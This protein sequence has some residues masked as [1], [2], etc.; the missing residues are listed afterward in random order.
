MAVLS[1]IIIIHGCIE[2][3]RRRT[4][5]KKAAKAGSDSVEQ[6]ERRPNNSPSV[7]ATAWSMC[8]AALLVYVFVLVAVALLIVLF[9]PTRF[10]R[11]D[12]PKREWKSGDKLPEA[13]SSEGDETERGWKHSC[14]ELM[15]FAKDIL[16]NRPKTEWDGALDY[17]GMCVLQE[18][19]NPAPRWNIAVALIEMGRDDEAL[20]FVLRALSLEPTNTDFL[21]TGGAFLSKRGYHKEAVECVERYLTLSLRVPSWEHLLASLSVQRE[22]EYVFL[23]ELGEDVTLT[24]ELLLSLYIQTQSLIKSGYLYKVLIGL[25]GPENDAELIKAYAFFSFG[26]GD[27]ATGTK[28]LRMVS[29]QLYI[30]QGYGDVDE[31][32]NILTAHCLRMLTASFDSHIVG[33]ARNLLMS[34]DVVMEELSYHCSLDD[35]RRN[36]VQTSRQT[37][38]QK[39]LR[40]ILALC[41]RSQSVVK[42]LLDEGAVVY[43]ENIF[44]WNPLLHA[45]ALGSPELVQELLGRGADP[46]SRTALAHTSLHVAAIRGGYDVVPPLV[47]AGLNASDVDYFGRTALQVACLQRWTAEGTAAAL[48]VRLL[49]REC[50]APLLY[51]PPLKRGLH[52][53]W[54]GSGVQLPPELTGEECGFDV[55]VSPDVHAFLFNY[56]ALQRPVLIRNATNSHEMKALFHLWQRN[57]LEQEFGS[58]EFHVV[59]VPYVKA[60]AYQDSNVTTLKAFLATMREIYQEHKN[61]AKVED[62]PGPQHVFEPVSLQSPLLREFKLPSV[63]NPSTTH[64]SM[65]SLQFYLGP[66]LSGSPA[67]FHG[68]TWDVLFYGQ[69]RWF[70]YPPNRAFYCRRHVWDWWRE[71]Y[72][73]DRTAMECVQH[74]GDL[75]FVPD[76]WGQASLNLRES[77]GLVSEFVYGASEFSI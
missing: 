54:L 40:E 24:F 48:G 11:Q 13:G 73:D 28:Y 70:L 52:G 62:L 58:H 39:A 36:S 23:F 63:L 71:T 69:K 61:S 34:G 43:A 64:I 56:L 66:A 77:V 41:L 21:K 3:R 14:S 55:L 37:V 1:W 7:L 18:P 26:L 44:G 19:D 49:P 22:D 60:F 25:K 67:H 74:P 12:G 42:S 46:Q 5:G 30:S 33:M 75:V 68:G 9:R 17:L 27:I 2:M 8:K 51:S 29:E 45:A 76:M 47:R 65:T 4:G 6:K 57:K 32:Y 53:G 10:S 15:T 20:E 38:N 16:D 31:A 72:R 50:P 59:E 35:K